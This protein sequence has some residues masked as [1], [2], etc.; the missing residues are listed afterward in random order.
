MIPLN[1][2]AV[3]EQKETDN[4]KRS[5]TV[6][7]YVKQARTRSCQSQRHEVSCYVGFLACLT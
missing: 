5:V 3:I 4:V 1:E 2:T 7:N 6:R